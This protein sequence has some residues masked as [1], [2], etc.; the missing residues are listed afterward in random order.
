VETQ[1]GC[2]CG[3]L[4]G[5]NP[6][7]HYAL[8]CPHLNW[9]CYFCGETRPDKFI[10]VLKIGT[11]EICGFNFKYCNDNM[12]CLG[13]A[14]MKGATKFLEAMTYGKRKKPKAV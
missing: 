9:K 7:N 4:I 3:H 8:D 10:S 2:T 5:Y 1:E 6:N 12:G 14:L 13:G 11:D